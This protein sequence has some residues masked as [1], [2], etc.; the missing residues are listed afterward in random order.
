MRRMRTRLLLGAIACL[1]F[2]APLAA[3]VAPTVT[4]ETGLFQILNADML[5]QGRF[6]LGLSWGLWDRTAASVPAATSTDR[7]RAR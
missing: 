7:S 3:Q 5:P 6:S 2:A 1:V 4:G